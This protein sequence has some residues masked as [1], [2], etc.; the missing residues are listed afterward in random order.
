MKRLIGLTVII[1]IFG[2]GYFALKHVLNTTD[3]YA[4]VTLENKRFSPDRRT[5]SS[6]N[7]YVYLFKSSNSKGETKDICLHADS[8]RE[9]VYI[10]AHVN[11]DKIVRWN[12]IEERSVPP[13]ALEKIKL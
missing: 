9:G 1:I 4:K 6:E 13:K 10:M 8:L 5:Y 3:Y 7:E 12:I 2:G 11:Y